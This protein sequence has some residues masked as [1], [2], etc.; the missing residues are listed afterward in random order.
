MI[1]KYSMS[2]S[3]YYEFYVCVHHLCK[4]INQKHESY[5]VQTRHYVETQ[6][7]TKIGRFSVKD[8]MQNEYRQEKEYIIKMNT[9]FVLHKP[10]NTNTKW[11]ETQPRQRNFVIY[12]A[13][14]C[15]NALE[16]PVRKYICQTEVN[17]RFSN[18]ATSHNMALEHIVKYLK[19]PFSCKEIL[20]EL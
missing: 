4:P 16:L 11:T 6:I 5:R 1:D 15:A 12:S 14:R 10:I 9:F 3:A 13:K 2:P 17:G 19:F 8:T 18:M 20:L 7:L